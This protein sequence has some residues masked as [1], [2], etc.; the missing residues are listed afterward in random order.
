MGHC[1]VRFVGGL[2]LRGEGDECHHDGQGERLFLE[3][4]H[5]VFVAVAGNVDGV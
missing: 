5:L 1:A 2:G 4:Q 3:H